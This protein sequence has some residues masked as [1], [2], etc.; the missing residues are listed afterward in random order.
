MARWIR[1]LP[2]TL[3][4][5][6]VVACQAG[7]PRRAPAATDTGPPRPSGPQTL[8][9][10][11]PA[12]TFV[13]EGD[14]ANLGMF[15]VNANIFETLVSMRPDFQ[16]EPGLAVRWD[17]RG[18]NTWRFALRQ[19]V[20]FHDGQPF[21][22]DAV[23]FSF[24]RMARASGP[25]LSIGPE[26]LQVVD[27][28]TVD[29]TTTEPNLNLPSQL[30]HPSMAPI[31]APASEVGKKP[32][33]TGPFQFVEY[34]AGQRLVVESYD[35]YWGEKARLDSITFQFIPD[36]VTRWL[37]LKTGEIDLLYDLP[38]ELLAEAQQSAGIKAGFEPDVTPAGSSE[39]MFLN[40]AGPILQDTAVRLTLRHAI[41]R[42]SIV[43]QIWADAAE[44]S[45]TVT[46]TVLFGEHAAV[47]E[48]PRYE[49]ARAETLLDQTGWVRGPDGIRV[50]DGQRLHLTMI[51]GYPPID[52]RKPMPE[53]VQAQ[54]REVGIEVEIVETPDL[55]AYTSRLD[56]GEGDIFL[57]R[58]AQNDA[59]PSFF[60]AAFFYS[61]ATGPYSRW[62]AAGPVFDRL[63]EESRAATDREVAKQKSA[64][65]MH[66]AIDEEVVVIPVAAAYWLFIMKE[67]VQGFVPHG[68]ARHVTWASVYRGS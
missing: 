16:L 37:A 27:D 34:V 63:V 7:G 68:S 62:F 17:Y 1:L 24:E 23:K 48:G 46:P 60:A 10:G 11:A 67:N 61:K 51:N 32:V 54:L 44:V 55:G 35:G 30:V 13:T 12:D 58:V 28:L 29:V 49:P 39:I 65:A 25:R 18:G 5:L 38:R 26:S 59:T 57:E 66:L 64:E 56:K 6:L 45:D 42:K 9:V 2:I 36:G 20:Q 33:G 14:K 52:I 21:N 41:D 50:K 40:R 15:P 8:V 3:V 4:A 19:G 43:D 47:I 31:I 22:A 53:L